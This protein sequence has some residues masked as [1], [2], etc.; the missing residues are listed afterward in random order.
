ML[1]GQRQERVAGLERTGIRTN[2]KEGGRTISI[3]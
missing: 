2:A 1:A 3:E